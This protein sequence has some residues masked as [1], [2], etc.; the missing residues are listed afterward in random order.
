MDPILQRFKLIFLEEASDLLDQLEKDLLDLEIAPD[1]QELIESAFR[2]MHTIKG[3]SGMY[4][5]DFVGEFTHNMENLYQAIRDKILRFDKDIFDVTF[6]S[7]DHIRKLLTDESLL[8][9]E[10]QKNQK[11]ILDAITSILA[12]VSRDIPNI[13]ALTDEV[14][15]KNQQI[16][17]TWHILIRTNEQIYFR[18]ISIVNIFQDLSSLGQ[19]EISRLDHLSNE[20]IDTWSVILYSSVKENDIREVFM[21]MEDDCTFTRLTPRNLFDDLNLD[22]A[23]ADEPSIMDYVESQDKTGKNDIPPEAN[24]IPEQSLKSKTK[25]DKEKKTGKRI[26]VDSE[27]LDH[28]MYLVSELITLNSQFTLNTSDN[29]YEKIWPYTERLDNLSKQFRNNALDIRLVPLS[30]S[31]LRFKRLIRDLSQH[32]NK[33]VELITDGIDTEVDKGTID[34]L[35]DPLMHIIRNCIDHGIEAPD[36]RRKKG[37][38]GTGVIKITATNSGNMVIIRVEDDGSGIDMEK[39]R[40]KAVEKGIFKASDTP[41]KQELTEMIFL[42][43]FSTAKSLTEVSGRGVGMDVVRRKITELRGEVHVESEW[44]IG[45]SFTLKLQQSIAIIDTLLFKVENTFFTVAISDINICLQI[46]FVEIEKRKHTRTIPF[47]NQLIPFVDIRSCFDLGGCYGE[48]TKAI[49]LK[50]NDRQMALLTDVIVGGHQAVLKPLGG[51]F[52]EQKCI[53]AASQLGDGKLAFMID[54]NELFYKVDERIN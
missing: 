11:T 38:S 5:F 48:I 10:N 16:P 2:A 34:Q 49:I 29:K 35:N 26:S 36:L 33:D 24:F 20:E 8:V 50:M 17:Y 51:L 13:M 9:P 28:L 27:K 21:F 42:P 44:G 39:I 12:K 43:G 19:F 14:N 3:V 47:E 6:Q 23:K 37:K 40:K 52:R 41:T 31:I 7:I 32:L 53:G 46:P 54:T 22:S 4:G 30:E 1:N 18:G 15:T 25:T 45:T